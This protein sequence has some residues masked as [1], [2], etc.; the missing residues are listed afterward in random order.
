VI[1]DGAKSNLDP[2]SLT[3]SL[4]LNFQT[5]NKNKGDENVTKQKVYLEKQR[6]L[7][8]VTYYVTRLDVLVEMLTELNTLQGCPTIYFKLK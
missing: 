2:F 7:T 4:I 1:P 5:L 8:Y 6:I 3:G